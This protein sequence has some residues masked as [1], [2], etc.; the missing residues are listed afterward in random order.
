[1]NKFRLYTAGPTPIPP[2]ATLAMAQPI[3]YHRSERFRGVVHDVEQGL[4]YVFRTEADV[5]IL[6]STGTG[7]MECAIANLFSPE[8][9]VI[10]IRSG[11]FGE[12][13]A[14]MAKAYGLKVVAID[15][16][17]GTSV[18]VREVESVLDTHPHAKAVLATL[19]ETSTGA[20]HDI[21]S[22]G[23]VT[24][25]RDLLLVCDA[26]SALG[27]DEMHMDAWHVDALVSCSQKALMTPPG[28]GFCALGDRALKASETARLPK[29][30][31]DFK[32]YRSNLPKGETPFTPAVSL[33]F[34]LHKALE[35]IREEGIENVMTRHA[36][37]AAATREAAKTL[38]L[39]L[40]AARP[41]NTVTAIG[42]PD[43]FDG[44][45]LVTRL[46]TEHNAVFAGGQEHL[47]GRIIRIAHLGWMDD[48]DAL[49]AVAALERGLVECGMKIPLGAGVSAAQTVLAQ[50]STE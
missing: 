12:R 34:G 18:D 7:G 44:K 11:K 20:L 13:W 10:A 40:F 5:A 3:D 26:V 41:A 9:E 36:R 17:W 29:Y 16:E 21:R 31:F 23:E 39:S 38:G 42:L 46:R 30:Y 28:L 50:S 45:A 35:R 15:L 6:A 47:A 1:M 8:D 25:G 43:G 4:Q 14:D 33:L 32:K 19:C 22:V 48:Y 49:V 37:L 24:R 27:A 2:D